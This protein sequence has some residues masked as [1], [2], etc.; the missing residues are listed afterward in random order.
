MAATATSTVVRKLWRHCCHSRGH[1]AGAVQ[2]A[3]KLQK[4]CATSVLHAWGQRPCCVPCIHTYGVA[5]EGGW[6]QTVRVVVAANGRS[7]AENC[8]NTTPHVS[9]LTHTCTSVCKTAK[10]VPAKYMSNCPAAGLKC[11][12]ARFGPGRQSVQEFAVHQGMEFGEHIGVA[13]SRSQCRRA[14]I[15]ERLARHTCHAQLG[16]NEKHLAA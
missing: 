7:E 4:G 9:W 13:F 15:K 12:D 3:S 11:K 5:G 6:Q 2:F 16:P 10:N 1:P 8:C 14:H